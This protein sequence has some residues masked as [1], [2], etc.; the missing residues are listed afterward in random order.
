MIRSQNAAIS[1]TLVADV[2]RNDSGTVCSDEP[3]FTTCQFEPWM[4][5]YA[6]AVC[7]RQDSGACGFSKSPALDACVANP[8][9]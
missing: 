2:R 6:D 4:A 7:E 9:L 5:C 1:S 3:V 8:A